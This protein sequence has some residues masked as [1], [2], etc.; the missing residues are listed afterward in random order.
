MGSS[1]WPTLVEAGIELLC[2]SGRFTDQRDLEKRS[3]R[4]GK[5]AKRV[6]RYVPEHNVYLCPFGRELRYL[7]VGNYGQRDII[8]STE[9]AQCEIVRCAV[10]LTILLAAVR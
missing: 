6:F 5:F 2:P 10:N 4:P 9:G 8:A 7:Q 1:R 3:S